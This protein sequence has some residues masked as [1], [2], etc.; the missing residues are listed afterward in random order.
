MLLRRIIA[1]FRK[2][3]WTAITIDFLIVVLGVFVATQVADWS[4]READARRGDA[5]VQRL[6]ADAEADLLARRR[7]I[8]YYEAVR[9]AAVRANTLLQQSSPNPRALVIAA[10]RAS[11]YSYAPATRATWDEIVS[12]G[13]IGLLPSGAT[14]LL[15]QYST[16]DTSLEARAAFATSAYRNRVRRTIPFEM[17]EAIRNGCSDSRDGPGFFFLG[18]SDECR[19]DG[20]SD[21]E[22]AVAAHALLRDPQVLTDLRYQLSELYAVRGNFGGDVALLEAALAA[23]RGSE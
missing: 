8:A 10:Y 9:D 5:Y 16:V 21:A 20:V 2:Q 3:E 15:A 12:S 14:A 19:L 7:S 1:H 6:I 11:E 23:L 13:D 18:F 17:Q 22:L 4:A